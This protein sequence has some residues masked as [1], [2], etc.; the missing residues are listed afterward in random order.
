MRKLTLIA[1]TACF[2]GAQ[3]LMAAPI[4]SASG[5]VMSS[6]DGLIVTV[7]HHKHKNMKKVMKKQGGGM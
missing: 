4:P 7:A 1:T 2:L 5:T 6:N 3:A